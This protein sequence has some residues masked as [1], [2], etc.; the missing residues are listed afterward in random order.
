M[1]V[2]IGAVFLTVVVGGITRLT[3]SGLS[4]T[5]WRPVS[6]V[7]PPM[8]DAE[9]QQALEMFQQIPQALTTHAGI[10][11]SEFKFI[12]WWEWFHRIV[13]R[14]VGLV[15]AVPFLWFWA[16]GMLTRRLWWRLA[17]LPLLTLGQGF[18]G[19]YMVQSG[20]AERTEVSAVR[21]AMHLSLALA[22][23]AVALWTYEDLRERPAEQAPSKGWRQLS[24]W[25]AALVMTT[26][27]AGAFV[28]GLRAGKSYNTFPLM[29]GELFPTGYGSIAGF[30][31]NATQNPIAA[32][33]HHR[34][35]GVGVALFILAVAFRGAKVLAGESL[36]M[37]KTLRNGVLVQTAL[38]VATLL[39]AVPV[40]LGA[41]HQ[42]VGVLVLSAAI[43]WMHRLRHP[44]AG[45]SVA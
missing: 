39:L 8:N 5:E 21:L 37:L 10:T 45:P 35:L 4:I 31:A 7:L 28:A 29:A 18:L 9:W 2:C 23:L 42:L 33:F 22:I 44:G 20:L 6:G 24:V 19:W 15:F 26:I 38:G 14:G 13:A 27:V 32:Q 30:L 40:W 17:W 34:W 12:Y 16:K 43:R 41:L 11:M 25:S 1:L 3:E 36:A